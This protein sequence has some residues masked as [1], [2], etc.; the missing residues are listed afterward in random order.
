MG[1][2]KNCPGADRLKGTPYITE[3]TCPAC[4]YDLE[5]FSNESET[6]CPKCGEIIKNTVQRGA[7]FKG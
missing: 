6:K 2:I 7:V 1:K 5:I 3:L 4:G